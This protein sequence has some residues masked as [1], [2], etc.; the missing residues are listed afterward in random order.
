MTERCD[1]LVIGGGVIGVCAAYYLAFQ[2]RRVTL[3]ERDEVC[4]G[5]SYGNSGLIV[6][7]HS[8]P[9]P[10]PGAVGQALRW[11]LNPESPFYVKPRFDLDLISWLWRF[12]GNCTA[13]KM[14]LGVGA[15]ADLSG[16]SIELYE[17][18]IAAE[19]LD[20][21]FKRN[22]ILMLYDTPRGLEEG[23]HEGELLKGF[24][25]SP[26]AMTGPEVHA[27]EPSVRPDVAGAVR[28]DGDGYL[29][30]LKFVT[31]LAAAL[32]GKGVSVREG[33]EVLGL[34]VAGGRVESVSTSGGAYRAEQVVLAAGS[35]SPGIVK[36]LPLKLPVQPAKGYS[37]TYAKPGV[38]LTR[39][40]I[41]GEARVG[42]NP[43]GGAIRIAGT[44]EIGEFDLSLDHRR[45]GAIARGAARYFVDDGSP[46][47]VGD[48]WAGL[49][50]CTPDGLP[51]V[52]AFEEVANLIVATGHAMLGMTLGP[53]TGKMVAELASGA[54]TSVDPAA[55][56][57][58]RFGRP[59]VP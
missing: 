10:V 31:G 35:W 39:P 38:T 3:L 12:R 59:S 58:G 57:P 6:P 37:L 25:L 18:I 14:R 36:G 51:I 20:C 19:S 29:D 15:L 44:L 5:S 45:I 48:H 9:L 2:G 28:Y 34:E 54:E 24:G 42:V 26:N 52:G 47:S 55:F 4:S 33:V 32:P 16:A 56:R 17:E 7:S 11:M 41:L 22:G 43:M 53:A 49:R 46:A 30:P 23:L 21:G 1:V 27:L 40:L 13:E 50:P 8:I